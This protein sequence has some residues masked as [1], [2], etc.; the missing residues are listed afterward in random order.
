MLTESLYVPRSSIHIREFEVDKLTLVQILT[1]KLVVV[2]AVMALADSM[3]EDHL[4]QLLSI[5]VA[6]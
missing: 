1:M 3:Q 4:A 2:V 5:L 6:F